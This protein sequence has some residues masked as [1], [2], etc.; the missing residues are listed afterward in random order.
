MDETSLLQVDRPADG[1]ARVR[2]NRPEARNALSM[3]LRRALAS[4]LQALDDD[5]GVRC[6]IVCGQPGYFAAGADLKEL[7]AL[8]P[9]QV[10]RLP[11][12]RLWRAVSDFS[13][14]M[15][16]AVSGVAFGGGCELA[17]HADVIVAARSSRF[18]LPEVSVGIMPGG[19]ATQRLVRSVGKYHAMRMMMTGEPVNA[20]DALA[21]GLVSE[22]VDDAALEGRAI[23]LASL[24]ASRP[25]VALRLLK[26]VALAGADASLATGLLL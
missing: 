25:P 6:V 21:M 12:L 10:E 19:G 8:S 13:K 24:I 3:A 23:E 26:Q 18:G 22:V 17:L 5:E 7:A 11:V 4:A 1:V 9:S 20:S 16:A 14:P 2:L 15:I